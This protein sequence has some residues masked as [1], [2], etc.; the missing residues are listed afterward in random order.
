MTLQTF[1]PQTDSSNFRSALG[2]FTTGVT[3]ITTDSP[4]GP[5]GIVA[6]SF[7]SVSLDPPLVLWSPAKASK[8]FAHFVDAQRF[9]IHVMAADQRDICAAVLGSK[10]AIRQVPTHL[11]H[12]GLPI[13][14]GALA[15]FEC[16]FE[17]S[18]DAGDHV[19]IIGR[20]T[21]AH[22]TD[23]A[24]LTFHGG[25]YGTFAPHHPSSE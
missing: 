1:D 8:R 13:I 10:T 5:I 17:T 20:V 22:F 12:C 11:S 14:A 3:V 25:Q 15:T 18:H 2:A 24:P 7:A 9:A 19:I 4:E 16:N 6:N 21:K 23:G